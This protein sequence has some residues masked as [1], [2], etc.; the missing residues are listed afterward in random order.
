VPNGAG[1]QANARA[2]AGSTNNMRDAKQI[3]AAEGANR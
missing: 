1:I 2:A 3:P